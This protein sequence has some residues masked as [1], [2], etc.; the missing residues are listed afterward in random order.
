MNKPDFIFR[1]RWY[2]YVIVLAGIGA[3]LYGY[4][5]WSKKAQSTNP[6]AHIKIE[7]KTYPVG[8][9]WGYDVYVGGG[10]MI[11]Q[12][13]IPAIPGD[14]P[15]KKEEEAKKVGELMAKKIRENIMPP[16]VSVEELIKLG[17]VEGE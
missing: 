16:S 14:V 5:V 6:Y 8:N 4:Y 9:G 7:V 17:V 2:V 13:H 12:P 3:G 1:K 15:F 10:L 11:H